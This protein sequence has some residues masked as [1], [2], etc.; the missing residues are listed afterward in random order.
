MVNIAENSKT[1]FFPCYC[2]ISK[3]VL[4]H[5]SLCLVLILKIRDK[6]KSIYIRWRNYMNSLAMP[7][8]NDR[9]FNKI[10]IGK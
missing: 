4:F 7:W 9:L 3:L 2:K 8:E 1:L 5:Y 10:R 6:V